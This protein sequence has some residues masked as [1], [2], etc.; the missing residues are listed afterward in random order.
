MAKSKHLDFWLGERDPSVQD[1]IKD[2]QVFDLSVL[3]PL[4]E[5][6]ALHPPPKDIF[7]SPASFHLGERLRTRS[8]RVSQQ[9]EKRSTN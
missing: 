4:K 5:Q 8:E 2:Q 7:A 9:S 1:S 6:I 3:Q